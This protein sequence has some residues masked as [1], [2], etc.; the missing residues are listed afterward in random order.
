[1]TM[2]KSLA[3]GLFAL[4]T[5]NTGCGHEASRPEWPSL[6]YNQ[7]QPSYALEPY[8]CAKIPS[9][10]PWTC[11]FAT[12]DVFCGD[13]EVGCTA[14]MLVERALNATVAGLTVTATPALESN[15]ESCY[16]TINPQEKLPRTFYYELI[17]GEL[18]Y[19]V[20]T[21]MGTVE[22]K[23]HQKDGPGT[24]QNDTVCSVRL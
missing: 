20:W 14:G 18:V 3:L 12:N 1:M 13:N 24:H 11:R 6:G 17:N 2:L 21:T 22:L 23:I 7:V 4:T 10:T 9:G 16:M 5:L 19:A 15:V 8:G